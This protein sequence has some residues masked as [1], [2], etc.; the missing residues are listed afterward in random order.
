MGSVTINR[1]PK[2]SDEEKNVEGNAIY[3]IKNNMYT[4]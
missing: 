3:H 4:T 1:N 2:S